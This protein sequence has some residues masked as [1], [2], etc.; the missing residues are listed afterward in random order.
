[1]DA[2]NIKFVK[3]DSEYEITDIMLQAYDVSTIHY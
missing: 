3:N 2:I 1:M